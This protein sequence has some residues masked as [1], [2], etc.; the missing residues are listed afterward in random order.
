M[1]AHSRLSPEQLQRHAG[2]KHLSTGQQVQPAS[3]P[4][5]CRMWHHLLLAEVGACTH[6]DRGQ[7]H[8]SLCSPGIE[9]EDVL[10]VQR[11]HCADLQARAGEP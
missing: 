1:Q 7:Q 9:F 6:L 10:M 11:V 8:C 5:S 3:S 4:A 2:S